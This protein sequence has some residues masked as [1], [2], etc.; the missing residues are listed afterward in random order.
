MAKIKNPFIVIVGG[1]PN[2]AKYNIQQV[3]NGDTCELAIVDISTQTAN[4]YFIGSNTQNDRQQLY[5][6][7]I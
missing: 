6:V 1:K 5:I 4:N 2:F 3:I 7:D